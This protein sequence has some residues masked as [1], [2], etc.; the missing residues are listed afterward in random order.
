LIGIVKGIIKNSLN[1]K[2][3]F[4]A[5]E[6]QIKSM[7]TAQAEVFCVALATAVHLGLPFTREGTE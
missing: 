2:I 5:K 3:T 7:A 4:F 6:Q 1:Y